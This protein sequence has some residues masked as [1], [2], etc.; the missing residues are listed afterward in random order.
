MNKLDITML[1]VNRFASFYN[2]KKY[3]INSQH[4]LLISNYSLFKKK[5]KINK[6]K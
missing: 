6:E 4:Q 2:I 3:K 1:I 5:I